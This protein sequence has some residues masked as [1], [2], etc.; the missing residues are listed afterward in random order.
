MKKWM[1]ATKKYFSDWGWIDWAWTCISTLAVTIASIMMWD[2]ASAFISVMC[3]IGTVTGVWNV[4]LVAKTKAVGN[5]VVG[6]IN[7]VCFG[8]FYLHYNLLGNAALNVLFYLPMLYFQL[9]IWLKNR[10]KAGTIKTRRLSLKGYLIVGIIISVATII[11]GYVLSQASPDTKIIG[12]FLTD[13]NPSPYLDA[14]TTVAS[15]VTMFL[16]VYLFME[17]WWLWV[18]IDLFTLILWI[19]LVV[20]ATGDEGNGALA[21]AVLYA[22]WLVS[23]VHGTWQWFKNT[24][25]LA[26]EQ[27]AEAGKTLLNGD[28]Q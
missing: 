28:A 5:V 22:C 10:T 4:I 18:V 21:M 11:F 25:K 15:I 19:I 14:F 6:T 1:N 12:E 17:Q 16:L 9:Y 3:L 27:A 7:C 2:P 20:R 26:K 23:A 24:K 13:I 8:I